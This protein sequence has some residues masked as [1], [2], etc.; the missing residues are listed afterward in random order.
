M[1]TSLVVFV[2][3]GLFSICDD[4]S[5]EVE[6][7]RWSNGL[8]APMN[9]GAWIK[10]GIHT[11]PVTVQTRLLDQAPPLD[12]GPWE[13]VVEASVHSPDGA[14]AIDPGNPADEPAYLSVRGPGWYRLRTHAFGRNRNPD[15][16]DDQPVE[17]Y[18]IE[19]WPQPWTPQTVLRTSPKIEAS[20]ATHTG[21]PTDEPRL[22]TAPPADSPERAR[23]LHHLRNR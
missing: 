1:D 8:L 2:N 14:L 16:V 6:T 4:A 13:E 17:T 20:L 11:G 3:D 9:H 7:T 15:G 21:E 23:L 18:L 10:T 22:D 5:T 12:S 19:A